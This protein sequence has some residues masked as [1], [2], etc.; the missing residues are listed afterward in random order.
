[1]LRI[2]AAILLLSIATASFAPTASAWIDPITDCE[3]FVDA[4]CMYCAEPEGTYADPNSCN[5]IQ[6]ANE[7]TFCMVFVGRSCIVH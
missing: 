5:E 6:P 2:T 1:M 7:W 4:R 3:T